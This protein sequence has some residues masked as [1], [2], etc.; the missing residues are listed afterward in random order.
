MPE[1]DE[2]RRVTS[3]LENLF[4]K[5]DTRPEHIKSLWYFLNLIKEHHPPTYEH[6]GRMALLG[7]EISNFTHIVDPKSLVFPC[8]L[9]DIGKMVIPQKLLDKRVNWTSEDAKEM[10][11]HVQL[12]FNI[13]KQVYEFSAWVMLYADH[14]TN[15]HNKSKE[16]PQIDGKFSRGTQTLIQYSGRL[17]A[18]IDF[19]EAAHRENDKFS[20]GIPKR[21]TPAEVKDI[22]LKQNKDQKHLINELYRAGI[23]N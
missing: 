3:E 9:H 21:L 23:F 16:M 17:V 1:S 20:P 5:L 6:S 11:P 13:L 15:D 7:Y 19:Y 10:E 22:T 14:F 2:T 8:A 4:G 18:L 12:G